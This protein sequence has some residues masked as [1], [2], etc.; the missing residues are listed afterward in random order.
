M[1]VPFFKLTAMAAATLSL[2]GCLRGQ[3][4]PTQRGFAPGF[5]RQNAPLE[6]N[7]P[8][9]GNTDTN[10]RKIKGTPHDG[11]I[12]FAAFGDNRNSSPFSTGANKIYRKVIDK[13]NQLQPDFAINTGD[14][15]FDSLRPHWRKFE[16]ISSHI[17]V[18]YLT[19]IGNH[20]NLF[21]RGYYESR[22]TPPHP[23]TGLD[24]YSFDY[25]GARFIIMDN[26]NYNFT[27]RQ[28]A[29]MEK[30]L[31][32]PLKK[33]VFAH[34]PPKFGVWDH[35]LA[36]SRENS[37]RW[38][39]LMSKYNVDHVVMGHIHL[40]DQ[41][42]IDGVTYTVTGGG[43]APLDRKGDYG[44]SLYHMVMFEMGP[45]GIRSEL[46]PI[47]TRI[48]THGPTAYTDGLEADEMQNPSVLKQY[49]NDYIPPEEQ[50]DEL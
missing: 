31:Q 28:F 23:E 8:A 17:R 3:P 13:V 35:K 7:E 20:D 18:P 9:F 19:V 40:Y 38:M 15:T 50:G 34:A 10:I 5:N 29:Y 16:E 26:A 27:E 46:V 14:F 42:V 49:P 33:F 30:M 44:Q 45:D 39:A 4:V 24:D 11:V 41:R 32:T 48:R 36:P 2:A 1:R 12:R 25:A 22:F 37:A 43:G 6:S 21:G 47:E